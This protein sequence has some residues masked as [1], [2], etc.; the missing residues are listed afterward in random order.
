MQLALVGDPVAHS[1]SPAI[2][3]A[4][5]RTTGIAGSYVARRTDPSELAGFLDEMRAGALDGANVTMPLKRLALAAADDISATAR[6][7]GA[8]N[9]LSVRAGAVYGSNTDVGGICDAWSKRNLSVDA[10]VLVLGTGGAA[11]AALLA[12]EG[13][14]IYLAGRSES[15]AFSLAV[16]VDVD[17]SIV[18]WGVV[19]EGAVVVNST[20]LGMRGEDLPA[21]LLG[22]ASGL[23]DMAYGSAPTPAVAG[24]GDR[25]HAD[26]IDMLVAQAARSFAIW[27]GAAAP[28]ADME[29]AARA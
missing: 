28:V 13:R 29:A 5:L 24:F 21:G 25:P 18:D 2:H 17:V 6:R 3:Q 19:V 1:L 8:A 14:E 26:G 22:A 4:A 15:K 12:L 11:A 23:F 20:P 10:P 7:A 27:T 9:T 16:A